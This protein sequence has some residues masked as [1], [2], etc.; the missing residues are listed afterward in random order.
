MNFS[1]FYVNGKSYYK[2]TGIALYP[3]KM[4][5]YDGKIEKFEQKLTP[6]SFRLVSD[7]ILN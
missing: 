3:T 1:G 7:E 4:C 6:P 5:H 2:L